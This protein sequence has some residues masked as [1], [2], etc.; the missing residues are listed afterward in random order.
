MQHLHRA[1]QLRPGS[2]GLFLFFLHWPVGRL[3]LSDSLILIFNSS[4]VTRHCSHSL[5]L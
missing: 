2:Q 3:S 1:S 4:L 5:P